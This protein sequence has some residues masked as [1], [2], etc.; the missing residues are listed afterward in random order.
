[1]HAWV[2][3]LLD[4]ENQGNQNMDQRTTQLINDFVEHIAEMEPRLERAYVFGS[5]A[6][7]M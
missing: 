7:D 3:E 6:R 5:Y 4:R 2:Y 1:M